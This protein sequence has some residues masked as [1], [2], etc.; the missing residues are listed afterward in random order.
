MK[1]PILYRKRLIPNECLL[2][3]QDVILD[4][5]EDY[6]I[7]SWNTIRPKKDLNRGISVFLWKKG[8]KV[9]KFYDH[10]DHLLCWYCDIIT[11][12]YDPNSN[13]CVIT[14]LLA[15]VLVYPN[16]QIRVV[17]LD[18]LSDAVEQNLLSRD[19]LLTALRQLNDLLQVIYSGRFSEYQALI[20]NAEA[21]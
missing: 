9:S 15:D 1:S 10:D 16:G 14:D 2:L 18:E 13:I 7:T 21:H 17:D 20:E 5:T 8:I 12:S 3:D 19:L 11:H 4:V 6:L